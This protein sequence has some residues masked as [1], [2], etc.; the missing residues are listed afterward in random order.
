LGLA[1]YGID[2]DNFSGCIADEL[3]NNNNLKLLDKNGNRL[4][5]KQFMIEYEKDT[6]LILYFRKSKFNTFYNKTFE[7]IIYLG[8]DWQ[9]TYKK[10]R[11]Q[12]IFLK[13][14][15]FEKQYNQHQ[16]ISE[17]NPKPNNKRFMN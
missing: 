1:K 15:I 14:R 11:N 10:L 3:N 9:E 4:T 2:L 13:F 17:E 7:Y 8:E 6:S 16:E 5:I 12:D